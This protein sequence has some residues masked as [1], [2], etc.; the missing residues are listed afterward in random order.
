MAGHDADD[1]ASDMIGRPAR[2]T[3]RAVS[4]RRLRVRLI[5]FMRTRLRRRF[6]LT[7]IRQESAADPERQTPTIAGI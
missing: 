1:L 7:P 2:E 4:A 6:K 5:L 3:D